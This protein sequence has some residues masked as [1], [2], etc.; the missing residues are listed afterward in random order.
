MI[1][2]GANVN[3]QVGQHAKL[4]VRD[5][6]LRAYRRRY[7]TQPAEGPGWRAFTTRGALR[8][9]HRDKPSVF[10]RLGQRWQ[11]AI[12]R[13]EQLRRQ[14]RLSSFGPTD[15]RSVRS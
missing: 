1:A 3:S 11:L 6:W 15:P 10:I 8:R 5:P 4:T 12:A 2:K 9:A 7:F 14:G 13:E